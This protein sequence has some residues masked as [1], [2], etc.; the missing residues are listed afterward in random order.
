MI[1]FRF[2]CA[3]SASGSEDIADIMSEE[4]EAATSIFN[5]LLAPIRDAVPT[6]ILAAIFAIIG[7]VFIKV[8]M[9][10][11]GHALNRT[12]MDGIAVG[13][14]RSIIR[15][16]LYVLL[17]VIL[18]S[19]LHVPMDS[20]VAVIVSSSM[21]VALALKDSLA[22]V[23]GGFIL[24]CAKPVKAGDTVELDGSKG[25]V[26]S[27]GILYTKI[28]TS[29]NVAVY[30]PNGNV[31]SSKIIN[32]TQKETRRVTLK[33]NISYNSDLDLAK[34][35]LLNAAA[36]FDE[37]FTE[38]APAVQVSAHLDSSVEL[39]LSVWVKTSDYWP[40]YHGLLEQ[41]KKDFDA[42]GIEIPYAQLDV[43]QR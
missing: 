5:Q 15:I 9:R 36:A 29:D 1:P 24:L 14:L 39:Q 22:N 23:A 40:V 17:A 28:V 19:V 26:E 4:V 30:I 3:T 37:I 21:A 8:L 32:Y 41:V 7:F 34:L 16:V 27:V 31:S 12:E 2:S 11:I 43:H 42:A 35:T 6:I 25:N 13:F 33:F 18:L 10:F 20:I 38:P